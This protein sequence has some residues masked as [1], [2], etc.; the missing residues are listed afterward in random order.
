M[1]RMLDAGGIP[2][3]TDGL[4][5]P[6]QHNPHG[7]FEDTRVRRLAQDSAW[8]DEAR[9]KAVKIIYRLL[10]HLPAHLDYRVLF[11]ERDL[12]EVFASQQDMLQSTSDPAAAQ[13]RDRMIRA[14]DAELQ[15]SRWWLVHQPDILHLSVP[16]SDLILN[17]SAWTDRISQFLDGG[18][19][20][21]AMADIVDPAL[22]RHRSYDRL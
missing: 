17:P 6:D 15:A 20:E 5:A 1:M 18:L 11:M 7:Y 21:S 22:Y 2:A 4:R 9:G 13:D 19:N 8:L 12:E 14:L 3:L 10:P 16:Y